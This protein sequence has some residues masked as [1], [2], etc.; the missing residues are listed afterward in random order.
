MFWCV[1][2]GVRFVIYCCPLIVLFVV[3][4]SSS[5]VLGL[6]FVARYSFIV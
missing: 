6:L 3:S 1:L 4:N 2:F 5:V